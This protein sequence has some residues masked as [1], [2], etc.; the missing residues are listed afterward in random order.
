MKKLFYEIRELSKKNN[1]SEQERIRFY[2]LKPIIEKKIEPLQDD[3][4]MS[5]TKFYIE[6]KT[7]SEITDDLI[8]V[9]EDACRKATTRAVE[10]LCK[11]SGEKTS[12]QIQK[13]KNNIEKKRGFYKMIY[14]RDLSEKK[15]EQYTIK[16]GFADDYFEEFGDAEHFLLNEKDKTIYLIAEGR[17]A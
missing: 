1:L 4:K 3:I 12:R 13:R 16:V 9:S 15:Y 5:I 10:K 2:Y 17:E 14:A 6:G 7:W 11:A 8:S